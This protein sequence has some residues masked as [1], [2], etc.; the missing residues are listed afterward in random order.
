MVEQRKRDT[1]YKDLK[2]KYGVDT[3][4]SDRFIPLGTEYDKDFVKSAQKGTKKKYKLCYIPQIIESMKDDFVKKSYYSLIEK[5]RSAVPDIAIR[6][7]M[8]V[9]FPDETEED[10]EELLDFVKWARFDRMGAFAYSEEDD[11]YSALHYADNISEDVK[12]VT[13]LPKTTRL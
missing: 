12:N 11:T 6:T 2:V 10:F 3:V 5:L 4:W 9:G 13:S 1:N 7:T 8:M